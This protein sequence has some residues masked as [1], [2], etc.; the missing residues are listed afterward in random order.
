MA[1]SKVPNGVSS[2]WNS[3]PG[4]MTAEYTVIETELNRAGTF[5]IFKIF[6]KQKQSQ[7][8]IIFLAKRKQ[9]YA[10]PS[11]PNHFTLYPS[12]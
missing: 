5:Y 4:P 11:S 6:L 3:V 1:K 10:F 12:L 9:S 8:G 2:P 7:K